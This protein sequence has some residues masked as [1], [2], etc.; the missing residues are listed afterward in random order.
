MYKYSIHIKK[1]L[2]E[3]SDCRATIQPAAA[4]IAAVAARIKILYPARIIFIVL[5]S[6]NEFPKVANTFQFKDLLQDR[7]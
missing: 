7:P 5:P 4:I 3:L 1:K 6:V 2:Q